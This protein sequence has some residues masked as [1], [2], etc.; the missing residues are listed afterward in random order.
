MSVTDGCERRFAVFKDVVA[1][2]DLG[3]LEAPSAEIGAQGT[4][5]GPF[6]NI[7]N[8]RLLV[9]DFFCFF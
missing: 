6:K 9:L 7:R 2:T 8:P 3:L 1:N 4:N 5:Y